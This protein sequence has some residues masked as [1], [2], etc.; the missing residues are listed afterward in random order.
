MHP[1][2]LYSEFISIN[3][4]YFFRFLGSHRIHRTQNTSNLRF[5][6][7]SDFSLQVLYN[8][9]KRQSCNTIVSIFHLKI[10]REELDF[11]RFAFHH[12]FLILY[13]LICWHKILASNMIHYNMT[14][15]VLNFVLS[16][17]V[18]LELKCRLHCPI[19]NNQIMSIGK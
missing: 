10:N 17:K 8:N 12:L 15:F 6:M 19:V 5:T 7:N 3:S 16:K 4:R 2:Y 18:A 1:K 13:G 11:E 14:I 9:N